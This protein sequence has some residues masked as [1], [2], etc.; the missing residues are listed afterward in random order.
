MLL[1]AFQ[2]SKP[3]H[4]T[5]TQALAAALLKSALD[6][7]ISKAPII[8]TP[9]ESRYLKIFIILSKVGSD[10]TLGLDAL[11]FSPINFDSYSNKCFD[12][13]ESTNKPLSTIIFEYSLL[14]EYALSDDSSNHLPCIIFCT[15]LSM[16]CIVEFL[17]SVWAQR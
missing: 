11:C 16:H 7:P 12:I 6:I 17:D 4:S 13:V 1:I 8:F 2:W 9:S 5:W 10:F 15:P 14:N 3:N